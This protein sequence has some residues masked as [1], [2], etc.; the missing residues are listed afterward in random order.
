MVGIG[1]KTSRNIILINYIYI[2]KYTKYKLTKKYVRKVLKY[3]QI[4]GI[5]LIQLGGDNM[6]Y[7]LMVETNK[8]KYK[9][10]NISNSKYFQDR[11]RRKFKKP[12]AYSL[13]EIDRFTTMFNDEDEMRDRMFAEGI[14]SNNDYSRNISIRSLKSDKYTKVPYGFMFQDDIEYLMEPD[15]LVKLISKRCYDEDYALIKKIANCFNEFRRCSSTAP[16]VSNAANAS[17]RDGMRCSYFDMVDENGDK[18]IDRF[19]K[20]IIFDS[21]DE[22]T[23]GRVIYTGKVNYR[24]LHVLIALIDDYDNKYI[25]ED[26]KKQENTHTLT[27]KLSKKKYVLDDQMSFDI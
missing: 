25:K 18:L 2:C 14:L 3:K 7:Y 10:L 5:I 16:E 21:Y 20:L 22:F 26:N 9:E 17:I 23:T 1:S 24:N 13:D 27:K 15:R 8:G 19:I 12:C 11:E 6:A 4:Y